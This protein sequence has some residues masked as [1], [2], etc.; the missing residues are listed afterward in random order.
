[1]A[2]VDAFELAV[3]VGMAGSSGVDAVL[4]GDDLSELGTNLITTL[5]AGGKMQ[6]GR[7]ELANSRRQERE[8]G[9][10]IHGRLTLWLLEL[11]VG[12]ARSRL[13]KQAWRVAN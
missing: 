3:G 10:R 2:C 7:R 9:R 6:T 4:V 12:L 8:T 1:M 13:D 5:A 11:R